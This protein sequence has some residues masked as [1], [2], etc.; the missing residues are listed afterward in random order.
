MSDNYTA[1]ILEEIRDQNKAVLEAVGDIQKQVSKIT[2]MEENITEIKTDI[3][4]IKAAVTDTNTQV[5]DHER[6]LT[7]LE[8]A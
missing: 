5:R 8:A 2:T 4:V 3:K 6:R 1:I 7:Q